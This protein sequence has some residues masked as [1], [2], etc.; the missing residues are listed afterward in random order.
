LS[1]VAAPGDGAAIGEDSVLHLS[2]EGPVHFLLFD[3]I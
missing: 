2:A 3:L 1:R